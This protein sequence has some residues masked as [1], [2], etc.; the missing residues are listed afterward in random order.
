M[1]LM[2]NKFGVL[3]KFRKYKA[4]VKNQTSNN[5]KTPRSDHGGEYMNVEFDLFL[6]EHGIV[7]QLTL[8][9]TP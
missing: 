3:D 2:K 1:Y 5:I 7:S 6:K 9:V 8:L 4:L